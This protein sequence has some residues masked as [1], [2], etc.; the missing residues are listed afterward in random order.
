MSPHTT[1]AAVQ[2][3]TNDPVSSDIKEQVYKRR[4]ARGQAALWTAPTMEIKLLHALLELLLGFP[5]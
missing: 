4:P 1:P 2:P 5:Q 3:G